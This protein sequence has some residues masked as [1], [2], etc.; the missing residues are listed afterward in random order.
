M[1]EIFLEPSKYLAAHV[2]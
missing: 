2:R 1:G